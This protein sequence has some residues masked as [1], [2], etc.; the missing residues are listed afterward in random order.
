MTSAAVACTL[1]TLKDGRVTRTLYLLLTFVFSYTTAVN[2]IERPDGIK[3]AS[4][5]ILV[6]MITSFTSRIMRSTELRINKVTLDVQANAFIESAASG[7]LH[8]VANRPGNIDYAQRA[9]QA[10]VLHNISEDE[11]IFVEVKN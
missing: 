3:I 1:T 8:L 5:F 6:I 11:I 9:N 10:A 2:M 4:F 7:I